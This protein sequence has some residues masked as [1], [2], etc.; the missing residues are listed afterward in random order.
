MRLK[1]INTKFL[2]WMYTR[3]PVY[4]IR[5]NK[6]GE[7]E[8][9]TRII[10]CVREYVN[11]TELI[12]KDK[13]NE[14][15]N[16]TLYSA[17]EALTQIFENYER[18]LLTLREKKRKHT[19]ITKTVNIL[20]KWIA[21]H[22]PIYTI[23]CE[24]RNDIVDDWEWSVCEATIT[25]MQIYPD[26]TKLLIDYQE[27]DQIITHRSFTMNDQNKWW[28]EHKEDAIREANRLNSI[29]NSTEE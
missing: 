12:L 28:F 11:L 23:Q 7:Y 18:A 26:R 13:K 29:K 5:E 10:A 19:D 21:D 25:A 20:Q 9:K 14:K 2:N 16:I 4:V 1:E 8:I 27:S 15:E 24:L 3:Q 6:N 17:D 22:K